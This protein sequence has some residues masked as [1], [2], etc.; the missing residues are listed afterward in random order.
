[1][2]APNYEDAFILAYTTGYAQVPQQRRNVFEGS[3]MQKP[4]VGEQMSIDDIGVSTLTKM[5]TKFANVNYSDNDF[6]RRW[7]FPEF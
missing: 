3:I 1:M 6:R 5:T 4:L 2:A 7:I